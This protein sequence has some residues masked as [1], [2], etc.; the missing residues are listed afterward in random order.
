LSVVLDVE[1]L[2]DEV[3]EIIDNTDHRINVR[4]QA[5]PR[6]HQRIPELHPERQI[7]ASL[8]GELKRFVREGVI[9]RLMLHHSPQLRSTGIGKADDDEGQSQVRGKGEDAV[10]PNGDEEKEEVADREQQG[11][12]DGVTPVENRRDCQVNQQPSN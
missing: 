10:F 9:H 11:A 6:H 12:L 3:S 5:R 2:T 8:S 1:N 7:L 4:L